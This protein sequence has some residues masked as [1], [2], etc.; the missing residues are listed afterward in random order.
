MRQVLLACVCVEMLY[1][2]HHTLFDRAEQT[3][4]VAPFLHAKP[5]VVMR[6]G[7][8]SSPVVKP[9][10]TCLDDCLAQG[11]VT[12]YAVALA[13]EIECFRHVPVEVGISCRYETVHCLNLDPLRTENRGLTP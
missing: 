9:E 5:A 7:F 6:V 2:R 11:N 8:Y 4:F 10:P 12:T 3:P 1:H 13:H